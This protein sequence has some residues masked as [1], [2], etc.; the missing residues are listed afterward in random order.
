M[1]PDAFLVRNAIAEDVKRRFGE[2]GIEIPFPHR[3]L[4]TG[5][6]TEPFPIRLVDEAPDTSEDGV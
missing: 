5:S 6:A 4:Y 3:S 2:E 1:F